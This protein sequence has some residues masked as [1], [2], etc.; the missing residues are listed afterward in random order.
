MLQDLKK[1]DAR[2]D[3]L[4]EK[5]HAAETRADNE[6]NEIEKRWKNRLAR[7]LQEGECA[8]TRPYEVT[9][10]TRCLPEKS[11]LEERMKAQAE[12]HTKAIDAFVRAPE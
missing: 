7:E 4:Q 3:D 6:A 2:L 9:M 10:V 11:K 1:K 8:T 12:E 5:L